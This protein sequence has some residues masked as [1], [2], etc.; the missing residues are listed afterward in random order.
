MDTFVQYVLVPLA[1]A[2]VGWFSR[3][4]TTRRERKRSDFEMVNAAISPLLEAIGKLTERNDALIGKLADEQQKTLEYMQ[5][6][7][8][9]LEERACLTAKID[10]LTKQVEALK[11]MLKE[12]L[13]DIPG[14]TEKED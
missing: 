10:R 13:K 5:R 9:L 12:H 11:K 7:R 2:V 8:D 14:D 3:V 6:T 1:G 4:L